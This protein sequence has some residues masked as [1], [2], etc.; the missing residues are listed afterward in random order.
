MKKIVLIII[1][2]FL[3]ACSNSGDWY[4]G[5][6][7]LDPVKSRSFEKSLSQSEKQLLGAGLAY[8][9][10]SKIE[11]SEDELM[12]EKN[13]QGE[14]HPYSLKILDNNRILV[15]SNGKEIEFGKDEHGVFTVFKA[16]SKDNEH[17]VKAYLTKVE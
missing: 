8:A 11:F 2:L 15:D 9:A 14:G 16:S 7:E 1:A 13:G 12:I 6:W 10:I 3:V 17:E 4:L 5:S